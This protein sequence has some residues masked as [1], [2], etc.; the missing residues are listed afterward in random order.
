MKQIDNITWQ[1]EEGMT[2]SR[3]VDNFIMGNHIQLGKCPL[4][5]ED[6]IIEHYEEVVDTEY[7]PKEDIRKKKLLNL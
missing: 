1:A 6:D 3:K 2:F 5:G 7:K 4:T